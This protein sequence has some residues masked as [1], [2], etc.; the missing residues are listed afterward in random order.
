[1]Y[2]REAFGQ[3]KAETHL[4]LSVYATQESVLVK[5]LGKEII[6]AEVHGLAESFL[7]ILASHE[8]DANGDILRIRPKLLHQFKVIHR[9]HVDIGENDIWTPK[10]DHFGGHFPIGDIGNFVAGIRENEAQAHP[11][12]RLIIDYKDSCHKPAFKPNAR[13]STRLMA[14]ILF[15]QFLLIKGHLLFLAQR[16]RGILGFGF[17]IFFPLFRGLLAFGRGTFAIRERRDVRFFV[18]V[19]R[20]AL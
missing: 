14:P 4:K 6:R 9:S 5:G 19:H 1:M 18:I 11:N 8:D 16:R 2:L 20:S 12:V 15:L 10:T 17:E 7:V 13:I 3:I